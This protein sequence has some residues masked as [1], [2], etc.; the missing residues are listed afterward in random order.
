MPFFSDL[1]PSVNISDW[2]S[3]LHAW[4]SSFLLITAAEVG[5][6]SQLV[7]MALAA[8]HRAL[9]V[10]LGAVT[11]FALLN[12]VAVLF[13]TA[14]ASWIP[15]VYILGVVA[16]LFILFGIHALKLDSSNDE[17]IQ[18]QSTSHGLFLTAFMLITLSEFGDKTQLAVVALSSTYIPLAVWIGATLALTLTS[19][20]GAYAGA[21]LLKRLPIEWLHKISGVFFL[22][23][24]GFSTYRLILIIY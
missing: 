16:L 18:S 19:V 15:D 9:P 6:K 1:V 4:L 2:Q 24:G 23:L 10:I 14:I 13:G 11:A 21:T 20:V 22:I 7:C 8:R 3:W 17:H 12:A 5:D